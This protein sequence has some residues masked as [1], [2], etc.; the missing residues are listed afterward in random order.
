M[1]AVFNQKLLDFAA[2]I[3]RL[4]AS[5]KADDVPALDIL[6]PSVE[7]I[8]QFDPKKSQAVFH[9]CVVL[10]YGPQI[11][12]R[13]EK[14]LLEND[15]K[16]SAADLGA[17]TDIVDMVKKVWTKLDVQ[18]KNAIWDHLTLLVMLSKRCV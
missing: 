9:E 16:E 5:G 1:L 7:M 8:M 10:R 14:F 17:S 18:E 3:S 15:Y 4:R 6:K 13:D 2:D 12:R 11:E